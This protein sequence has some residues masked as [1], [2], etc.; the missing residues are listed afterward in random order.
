MKPWQ[1]V[2][3]GIMVGLLSSAA[4][5]LV[6][7]QPTG[8]PVE[9]L[10]APTPEPIIVDVSGEVFVPGIYTLP[11]NSRVADAIDIAGGLLANAD[12]S[13]INLA[14]RIKD[15]DK[16]W[17]P[18]VG[19]ASTAELDIPTRSNGVLININT[20]SA[21][22]IEALPGIGE[23]KA[24]QI[25]SYRDQHGLFTNIEDLLNIPGIG[26]ELLEKIRPSITL[27]E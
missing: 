26:P 18:A 24:A 13:R 3:F 5:L 7:M 19:E 21:K 22:E 1:L 4:I 25:I 17:V 16:V 9:I 12:T 14:A 20:A 23:V 2:A 8:Q 6:I 15:G 27:S 10:P 11:Q